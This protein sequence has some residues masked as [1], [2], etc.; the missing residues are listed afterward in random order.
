MSDSAR[1]P[2]PSTGSEVPRGVATAEALAV[3]L[4][5]GGPLDLQVLITFDVQ[6]PDDVEVQLTAEVAFASG[7]IITDRQTWTLPLR[8]MQTAMEVADEEVGVGVRFTFESRYN[9]LVLTLF[10]GDGKGYDVRI[11][12]RPIPKFLDDVAAAKRCLPD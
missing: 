7:V 2:P 8:L 3:L 5:P 12:G 6:A 11:G 1:V 4:T 10:D 9:I